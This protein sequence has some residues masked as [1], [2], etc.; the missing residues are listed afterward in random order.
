MIM[1]RRNFIK[2]SVL[3]VPLLASVPAIS[4]G[5]SS[6]QVGL[7]QWSLHRALQ[8]KKIDN[9]EFAQIAKEK[10]YE[11]HGCDQ[12]LYH[13]M[14]KVLQRASIKVDEGYDEKNLPSNIDI[15]VIGNVISRGNPLM[16]HILTKGYRYCSGPDF[17]YEHIIR[18][19]HVIAVS[20][21]HG[22]TSVSA[23]TSKIFLDQQPETGYLIAGETKDFPCSSKFGSGDFFVLEADEYD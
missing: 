15:F 23:M 17:L 12:K 1:L 19:K 13:P 2:K 8:S 10:G 4:L 9:L 18:N 5:S 11:V 14:D 21:T 7:A 22:K 16:E 6:L 20:G 3:S